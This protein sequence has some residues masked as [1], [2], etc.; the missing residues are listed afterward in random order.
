MLSTT[1]YIQRL[2]ETLTAHAGPDKAAAMRAYMKNQFDFIGLKAPELMAL[3]KQFYAEY[4]SPVDG[5]LQDV[6]TG[7]WALSE[8]EY[9]YVA[10]DML[11]RRVKK[12]DKP[13]IGLFE[14]L[15][16][17]KPWWDT[18]D[19]IASKLIGSFMLKYPE[20][21]EAYP[22]KWIA[23]DDMW[24]QRTAILFQLKYKAKT[25]VPLLYRYID[26]C[27]DSRE[28][29][30]QKAIGWALREYAK[31]DADAVRRFVRERRLAPL[32]RRE[33]L[34]GMTGE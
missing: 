22:E 20:L 29:F 9:Q 18:I 31:T 21:I 11:E 7:L 6:V 34:K 4:G 24:L 5:Q 13:Y 32:S 33:A 23:S 1:D 3:T 30:I 26:A 12:L 25:N 2:A 8:R 17:T 19:P 28:F 15:A 27:I 16:T 14:R 10:L